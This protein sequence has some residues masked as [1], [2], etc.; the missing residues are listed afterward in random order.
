M[1]LDTDRARLVT[2]RADSPA[3]RMTSMNAPK[4]IQRK[5][6]KGWKMPEGVVYVGAPTIWE[7]PHRH[8]RGTQLAVDMYRRSLDAGILG[9]PGVG[10]PLTV[11]MIRRELR[12]KDLAC[13]CPLVDQHDNY[14]PCH[15][16]VLLS[17]AN[18]I[19][20]DEVDR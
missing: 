13:W 12:G 11:E 6:A 7:N 10:Q 8:L 17:L 15:A 1:T 16:D 20:M 2:R 18:N 4:R 5:R 19:P 3:D 9:W 14:M